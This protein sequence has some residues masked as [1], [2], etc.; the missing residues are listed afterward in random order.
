MKLGPDFSVPWVALLGPDGSGK[1]TL[2]QSLE[3]DFHSPRFTGVEVIY[4]RP[5]LGDPAA[6]P[7]GP[8]VA[9]YAKPPH[10]RLK[11][12]AKLGLRAADWWLGYWRHCAGRRAQGA[13]LL[14]DRHYFLDVIID[15]RRYRYG[16]PGWFARSLAG[17]LP[18][19]DLFIVL[20]APVEVLQRR[21]QEV[22]PAECERQRRAYRALAGRLPHCA[23][24]DTAR[25]FDQVLAEVKTLIYDF[26]VT[27]SGHR[28]GSQKFN[29]NY[30]G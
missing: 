27:Y 13:L 30:G 16:G 7:D 1:S 3:Q 10:G 23:I 15:P 24:V 12:M 22:S 9:H 8:A 5:S 18:R 28:T 17:L 11:S 2:L 26:V 21:K 20:D 29:T 25:P 6:G 19:P 4:R 14:L